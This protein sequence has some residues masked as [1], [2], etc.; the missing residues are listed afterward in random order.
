VQAAIERLG[1]N[2]AQRLAERT[3]D[4]R[5]WYVNRQ[6][7]TFVIVD[8]RQPFPMGSPPGEPEREKNETQ[9]QRIIGRRFAIAASP[10]TK[11]QFRRFLREPQRVQEQMQPEGM[12]ESADSPQTNMTWYEAAEYCNWLSEQEGIPRDQW[13]YEPNAKGDF[14]AEMRTKE[15]YLA[16]TGYRLPTEAEWEFACRAGTETRFYFGQSDSLLAGYAWYLANSRRHTWPVARLKPND[17]GL[18]DMLGNVWQWCE[19]PALVYPEPGPAVAGDS[20]G[21]GKITNDIQCAVRGG[22]FSNLP[23]HVRAAY[24]GLHSPTMHEGIF[25][26]RAAR[27]IAR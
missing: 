1:K 15:G 4:G 3:T 22:A 13:C 6:G 10:V 14:A 16:L 8:G 2:E 24:R 7:Q 19:G 23:G 18:F 26:F 9:H 17:F 21:A 20:G 12:A 5:Q 25:G 11:K 27:T